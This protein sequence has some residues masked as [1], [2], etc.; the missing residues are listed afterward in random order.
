MNEI[1]E[2]SGKIKKWKTIDSK[3]IVTDLLLQVQELKKDETEDNIS[4]LLDTLIAFHK[5]INKP[6]NSEIIDE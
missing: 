5:E 3:K 4:S 6:T 2:L 1:V